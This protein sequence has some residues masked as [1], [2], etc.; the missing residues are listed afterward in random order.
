MKQSLLT[1]LAIF[2]FFIEVPVALLWLRDRAR[3]WRRR[4]TPEQIQTEASAYRDRLLSPDQNSVEIKMGGLLP[5]SLLKLYA[6]HAL[7]LARGIE[8]RSPHIGP[9]EPG[10]CIQQFLPLDNESQ[11]YTCDLEEAGW[12]KG[13]CFGADGM[14]NFYWVPVTATRQPDAPVYFACHD[15]WGNEKIAE[16][17]FEFL[18][19]SRV[20]RV[21][22]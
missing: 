22:T 4:K 5:E 3:E 13:F 21:K 15:P 16:S 12:G 1:I 20:P 17:L 11:Q 10:R 8:I 7:V 2:G 14:G 18:S 19:R 9:H 6:D